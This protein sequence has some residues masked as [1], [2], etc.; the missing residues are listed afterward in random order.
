MRLRR[1][2]RNPPTNSQDAQPAEVT[3]WLAQAGLGVDTARGGL[4][5][6]HPSWQWRC[7]GCSGLLPADNDGGGARPVTAAQARSADLRRARGSGRCG[8]SAGPLR[9]VI[10][11]WPVLWRARS[12]ACGAGGAD[13]IVLPPL[14][15]AG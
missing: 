8:K 11:C 6:R 1:C 12:A 13:R 4:R 15:G 10:P 3:M 14:P 5:H 7:A 2:G 9:T